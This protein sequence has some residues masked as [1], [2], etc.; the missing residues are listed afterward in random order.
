MS[1]KKLYK[2]IKVCVLFL[3]I[4][5]IQGETQ[6]VL[7]MDKWRSIYKSRFALGAVS[8]LFVISLFMNKTVRPGEVAHIYNPTLEKGKR[9]KTNLSDKILLSRTT[10]DILD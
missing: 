9:R 10:Q 8:K 4:V 3:A 1:R 2:Q 5:C 6:D 7:F